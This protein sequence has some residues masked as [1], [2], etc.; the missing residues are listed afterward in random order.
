M[1]WALLWALG[2]CAPMAD[3][4]E[5]AGELA[6]YRVQYGDTL[7]VVAEKLQFPGGSRALQRTLGKRTVDLR[8]DEGLAI[9]IAY[10]QALGLD[11]ALDLGLVP[12][13]PPLPDEPFTEC[14][15]LSGTGGCV[16]LGD[17]E[18]C[19]EQTAPRTAVAPVDRY[20]CAWQRDGAWDCAHTPGRELALYRDGVRRVIAPLPSH[21]AEGSVGHD[22]HE[23]EAHRIDLD[24]DRADEL[25][26]IVPLH[27]YSRGGI[28]T[29]RAFV[30]DGRNE[31]TTQLDVEH[32]GTGSIVAN[33]RATCDVLVTR[34]EDGSLD[35][36]LPDGSYLVGRRY[37]YE[38][39]ELLPDGER[40]VRRLRQTF[41][42]V[43]E[44]DA[45]ATPAAWLTSP[46]SSRWSEL[47]VKGELRHGRIAAIDARPSAGVILDIA[48]ADGSTVHL[49]PDGTGPTRLRSLG[50]APTSSPLAE[51]YIPGELARW[52]GAEVLVE[53]PPEGDDDSGR[54]VWLSL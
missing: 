46:G 12:Y 28:E 33:A 37:G 49:D 54:G 2:A 44:D 34:W 10:T 35:P 50:W 27:V 22:P 14:R 19:V 23:L 52:S 1:K 51:L 45:R 20:D 4:D 36:R 3:E 18:L 7:G 17:R 9:P 21:R 6:L 25:I 48:F 8:I 13:E 42:H 15:T 26:A 38:R 39:G 53:V 41:F 40:H 29:S 30:I 31:R 5:P 16:D 43:S 11:P 47:P 24:G 32:W